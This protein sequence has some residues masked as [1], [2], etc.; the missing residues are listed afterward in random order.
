[1]PRLSAWFIRASMAYLLAGFTLGALMLA[2]KGVSYY[3]AIITVLPIHMEFLLVGWL[4]Q[5]AMGMA[6]WI[7]PRWGWASPRSRGNQEVIWLSFWLL[8]A[9]VWIAAMAPW[10][11]RALLLGRVLQVAAVILYPAGSWRRV[12]QHGLEGSKQ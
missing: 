3:P 5:L 1:M 12:K 6:F 2:Q 11:Q 8:N 7:F 9:G 4:V 10:F